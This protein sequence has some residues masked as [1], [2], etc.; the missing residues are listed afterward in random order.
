VMNYFRFRA[1]KIAYMRNVHDTKPFAPFIR[2][3]SG[4]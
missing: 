1:G 3:I 2:Q 4:G